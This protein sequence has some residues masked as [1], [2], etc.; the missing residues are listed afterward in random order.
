ML[1]RY[2][3][4][5]SLH[6]NPITWH[7]SSSKSFLA[8]YFSLFYRQHLLSFHK[9]IHIPFTS[10]ACWK[11]Q[12]CFFWSNPSIPA[13]SSTFFSED[14]AFSSRP[15]TALFLS[16]CLIHISSVL[17]VM[18]TT[19]TSHPD[20][21]FPTGNL[22]SQKHRIIKVRKDHWNHQVPPLIEHHLVD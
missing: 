7:S 22:A 19:P 12:L 14:L 18:A 4:Y 1:C 2:D 21:I 8:L 13:T 11:M 16:A 10:T 15:C 3:R 17:V 6:W 20:F 9:S 5:L